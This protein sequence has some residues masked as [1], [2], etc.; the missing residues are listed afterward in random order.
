[1][2]WAWLPPALL[3][4]GATLDADELRG[5]GHASVLPRLH[6]MRDGPHERVLLGGERMTPHGVIRHDLLGLALGQTGWGVVLHHPAHHALGHV[7]GHAGL[8]LC[9]RHGHLLHGIS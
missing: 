1:M 7:M 2:D 6:A 5:P 8:V 9:W 3:F 4:D